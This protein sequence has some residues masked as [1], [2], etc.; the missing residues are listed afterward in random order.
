MIGSPTVLDVLIIAAHPD[1]AEIGA[2]GLIA[3]L[4]ERGLTVGV[5][6][7]TNGEPTPYGSAEQRA[8]E[9]AVAAR[10]LGLSWR[11]CLGLPNRSLDPTLDAAKAVATL[12]RL[13]RPRALLAHYWQDLHPDHVAAS[14]LA[15]KAR[16]WAKLS[17]TDLAGEP[18]WAGHMYYF[19]GAHWRSPEPAT[20]AVDVSDTF[21]RKLS[22]VACYESQFG[23]D[24]KV[25][26]RAGD[27]LDQLRARARYWGWLVGAEY[28]EPY[29]AREP[30]GL[31]SLPGLLSWRRADRLSDRG[32]A[33]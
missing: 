8:R 17:K 20:F 13:L 23:P 31:D 1:D 9:S 14:Q 26:G 15:D 24:K 11:H 21:E 29:A 27:V 33:P 19:F 10:L 7:L 32:R 30:I 22:A 2:G 6:D 18:H 12:L 25:T 4:T 28:A 3:K 5:L 16:F